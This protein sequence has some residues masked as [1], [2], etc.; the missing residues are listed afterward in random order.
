MHCLTSTSNE[1]ASLSTPPNNPCRVL[2]WGVNP[3]H[4]N[5]YLQRLGVITTVY[6]DMG[7]RGFPG[8]VNSLHR[9]GILSHM[10]QEGAEALFSRVS[11]P[12]SK[13]DDIRQLV[14]HSK[15]VDFI[16]RVRAFF[17]T[18]FQEH[19]DDFPGVHV[20]A[21]FLGSVF[22]SV[23]HFALLRAADTSD[24]ICEEGYR[25]RCTAVA[26]MAAFTV[27][28]VSGKLSLAHLLIGDLLCKDSQHPLFR[29]TYQ[30]AVKINQQLA[31]EMECCIM[32]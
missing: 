19:K 26:E 16:V 28:C 5:A 9:L 27:A 18:K 32:R 3:D 11:N 31:D 1:N 6:N 30:F 14:P 10:R 23:D 15:F 13:H 29:Q 17:V 4:R 24:L 21:L 8:S 20:E 25:G 7:R 2:Q 22:H 12:H